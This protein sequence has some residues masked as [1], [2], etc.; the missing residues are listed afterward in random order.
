MKE[1]RRSTVFNEVLTL[2]ILLIF[3][4]DPSH[5]NSLTAQNAGLVRGSELK[6]AKFYFVTPTANQKMAALQE[7]LQKAQ[8][9]PKRERIKNRISRARIEADSFSH[10]LRNAV[11]RH[12]HFA[13]YDF[14]ADTS[15]KQLLDLPL[16]KDPVFIV[17]RSETESG[18]DALIVHNLKMQPLEPP[19]P[20]YARLTGLSSFIDA[21]FGNTSFNWKNLEKVIDKWS[22]RM[23]EYA[24][25]HP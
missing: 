19:V 25:R 17:R 11:V 15:L 10:A 23:E 9:L 6:M 21:F 20:Y 22:Q 16:S 24:S 8:D 18:A 2:T 3:V 5:L 12:F 1:P 7:E 4:F 13:D 14:V